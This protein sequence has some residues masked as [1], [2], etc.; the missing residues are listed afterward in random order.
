MGAET[1]WLVY[2]RRNDLWGETICLNLNC[3]YNRSHQVIL[4]VGDH[5]E[6]A[7]VDGLT[8]TTMDEDICISMRLCKFSAPHSSRY[9]AALSLTL[10]D[11]GGS[12]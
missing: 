3:G 8:H 7:V 1:P 12:R 9:E 2:T 10:V 5:F 4:R 11:M 6:D